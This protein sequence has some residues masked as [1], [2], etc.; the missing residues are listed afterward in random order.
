M[1]PNLIELP[2]CR[3]TIIGTFKG[4]GTLSP[5]ERREL[6]PST[7]L[8][9]K[10]TL[11]PLFPEDTIIIPKAPVPNEGVGSNPYLIQQEWSIILFHSEYIVYFIKGNM[12][13]LQIR[14]IFEK[15]YRY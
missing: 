6:A 1:E 9:V 11:V 15:R 10:A 12:E 2:L 13:E 7:A 4:A 3:V 14:K 8:K 5:A